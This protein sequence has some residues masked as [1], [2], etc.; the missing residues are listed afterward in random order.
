MKNLR[1]HDLG[2]LADLLERFISVTAIGEATTICTEYAV[3]ARYPG[4]DI[5]ED[6]AKFAVNYARQI[7]AWANP[8]W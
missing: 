5:D 7:K 4:L 2:V 1:T 8:Q 6:E 3:D